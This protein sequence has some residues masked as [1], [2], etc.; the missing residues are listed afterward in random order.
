MIRRPPR[1][2]LF[3]YTTLFRSITLNPQNAREF[4][5]WLSLLC[6]RKTAYY[7]NILV[8]L[9]RVVFTLKVAASLR[10]KDRS[11]R[12]D[13][14]GI[15]SLIIASGFHKCFEGTERVLTEAV[16]H[17][18][19]SNCEIVTRTEYY[20]CRQYRDCDQAR[21]SHRHESTRGGVERKLVQ[22]ISETVQGVSN[23]YHT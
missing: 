12:L 14:D 7:F 20:S 3:P 17:E 22:L 16:Y 13:E 19:V 23:G 11:G 2:T 5:Y 6:A 4:H 15:F 8:G 9:R 10:C 21:K 18:I 1:S